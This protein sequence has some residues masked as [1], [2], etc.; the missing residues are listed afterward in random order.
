M[1]LINGWEVWQILV[2][3]L[4]AN[5]LFRKTFLPSTTPGTGPPQTESSSNKLGGDLQKSVTPPPATKIHPLPP[6]I[7]HHAPRHM[8][9]THEE[10]RR[11]ERDHRGPERARG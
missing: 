6:A 2:F 3:T 1:G 8:V 5:P 11:P 7:D 9:S 10:I 4:P